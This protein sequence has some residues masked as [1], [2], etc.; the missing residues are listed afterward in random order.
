M[1]KINNNTITPEIIPDIIGDAM[2]VGK[3]KGK[4]IDITK[5][6]PIIKYSHL[7]GCILYF[8][9]IKIVLAKLKRNIEIAVDIAAP[10]IPKLSIK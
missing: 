2:S 9:I 3:M 10:T 8:I 7:K 4:S 6:N 1:L 5:N